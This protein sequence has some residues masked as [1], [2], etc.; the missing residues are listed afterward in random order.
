MNFFSL[1]LFFG[2][3]GAGCSRGQQPAEMKIFAYTITVQLFRKSRAWRQGCEITI[4][5]VTCNGM[6]THLHPGSSFSMQVT[7]GLCDQE[8]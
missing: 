7:A 5:D 6:C 4:H 1:L 3:K 8:V 2:A